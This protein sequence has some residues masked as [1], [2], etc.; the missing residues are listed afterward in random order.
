MSESATP[1]GHED[2]LAALEDAARERWGEHWTIRIQQFSDGSIRTFAFHSKGRTDEGQ[3][4]HERLLP[5]GDD[6]FVHV[7]R[8][9][10]PEQQIDEEVLD[11]PRSGSDPEGE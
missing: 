4:E 5:A 9:F 8:V 7:R 10:E 3:L 11:D 1:V 6:E 2:H